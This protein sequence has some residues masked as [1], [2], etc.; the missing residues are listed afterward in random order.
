MGR[1]C[2]CSRRVG[3]RQGEMCQSE[4]PAVGLELMRDF[5][6]RRILSRPHLPSQS[7]SPQSC[8]SR[9][10]ES[11]TSLRT[12][13]ALSRYTFFTARLS[14]ILAYQAAVSPQ[15]TLYAQTQRWASAPPEAQLDSSLCPSTSVPRT[16]R[17]PL[18]E[19]FYGMSSSPTS[20]NSE[21]A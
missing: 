6:F 16:Q 20:R 2:P 9:P 17:M 1:A 8:P 13:N 7:A 12:K 21:A 5:L 4:D 15:S 14:D 11:F 19:R 3:G 18:D 10:P